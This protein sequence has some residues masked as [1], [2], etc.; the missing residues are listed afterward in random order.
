[1][2]VELAISPRAPTI[3]SRHQSFDNLPEDTS[4]A[5]VTVINTVTAL[6]PKHFKGQFSQ[7]SLLHSQHE[8]TPLHFLKPSTSIQSNSSL[9]KEKTAIFSPTMQ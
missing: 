2:V 1:M 5:E 3:S 8:I 4:T 6:L 9:H 7:N